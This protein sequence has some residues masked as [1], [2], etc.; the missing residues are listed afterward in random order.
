MARVGVIA[1]TLMRL[2]QWWFGSVIDM[3]QWSLRTQGKRI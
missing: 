1:R 3:P 2:E